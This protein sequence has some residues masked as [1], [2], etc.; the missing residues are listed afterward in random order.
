M[1]LRP[2]GLHLA[3]GN[4]LPDVKVDVP[5]GNLP[6][7]LGFFAGSGLSF[8]AVG[9]LPS[10]LRVL[11]IV[12]GVGLA[13]G[14]VI[15][16]LKKPVMTPPETPGGSPEIPAEVPRAE[17]PIVPPEVYD[18]LTG[19]ILSPTEAGTITAGGWWSKTFSAR[20][21]VSNPSTR[22]A[23]V[24]FQVQARLT[25]LAP[26]GGEGPTV[27]QTVTFRETIPA[28]KSVTLTPSFNGEISRAGGLVMYG[29]Y[30]ASLMVWKVRAG[31]NPYLLDSVRFMLVH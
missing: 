5:L 12:S 28:G 14:G 22:P 19:Q 7:A 9:F 30:S 3:Q 25:A 29:E 2:A 23:T 10:E 1:G 8:I 6:K 4:F 11:G 21:L 16:L 15:T 13:A 31:E 26:L 17:A 27:H 24:D 18:D 20:I